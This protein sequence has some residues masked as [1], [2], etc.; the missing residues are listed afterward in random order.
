MK[1]VTY[2]DVKRLGLS[3]LIALGLTAAQAQAAI[4]VTAAVGGVT[5]AQTA[6]LAVIAALMTMATVLF[7]ITMVYRFLNKKSGV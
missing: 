4:D 1:K 6:I 3:G 7:G 5:D 2:A